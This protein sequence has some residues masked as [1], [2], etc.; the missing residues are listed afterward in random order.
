MADDL[1]VRSTER[2]RVFLRLSPLPL[3]HCLAPSAGAT[4]SVVTALSG[5]STTSACL[6]L[7][8]YSATP[9]LCGDFVA[10]FALS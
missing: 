2:V 4:T 5:S 9:S 3:H 10:A 1:P 7:V 6:F 8:L